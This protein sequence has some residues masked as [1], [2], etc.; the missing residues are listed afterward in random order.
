MVTIITSPRWRSIFRFHWW[1]WSGSTSWSASAG[2]I[3]V[4]WHSAIHVSPKGIPRSGGHTSTWTA[5]ECTILHTNSTK[6][7]FLIT[8]PYLLLC[9]AQLRPGSKVLPAP[10]VK[11]YLVSGKKCI[12]KAKT[13][14]ARKT[15]DPLYQQ[16]LSFREP[17]AGCIL[18][19]SSPVNIRFNVCL[20]ANWKFSSGN[21]CTL[22]LALSITTTISIASN[23]SL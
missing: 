15:L 8:L 19:V 18:Q 20:C 12:V 9:F 3:I 21:I 13:T 14:T 7:Y 23:I 4:G 1:S 17:F 10:Y 5:S 16:Q 6:K 11:V 22:H 2:C